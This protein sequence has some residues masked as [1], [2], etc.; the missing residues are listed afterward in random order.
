MEHKKNYYSSAYDT[1]KGI[2]TVEGPVDPEQMYGC[3]FADGLKAF[4]KPEEQC[5]A[6]RE[7]AQLPEGRLIV[8]RKEKLIVG[9]VVFL[10][11]DP[12]ERWSDGN[13]ENL[14][15]LGAI[16]VAPD[17]RGLKLGEKLLKTAMMDDNIEDYIIMTT[18]YYWHWDLK[19]S[20]LDAWQ[21]RSMMEKMMAAVGL[22]WFATDDEEISSHP[23]NCL[24]VRIGRNVDMDTR[25]KFDKL[26][27]QYRFM[28]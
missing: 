12:Q 23:A 27:F 4:R 13:I 6:M 28:Y 1:K 25:E 17:Y 11:P 5:A 2:I 20:G 26:R 10:Y 9:Y 19:G 24:M 14:L 15:E 18:E 8:A 22:T 21:Y 3:S 16:E 7:I